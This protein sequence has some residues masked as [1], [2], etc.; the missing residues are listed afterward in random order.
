MRKLAVV[1]TWGLQILMGVMFVALGTGKFND[2]G[3][4]RSFARWGYPEGF[5]FVI[6]V[7][8][9][10]GGLALLVP[11]FVPY[12]AALLM[13]VMLGAVLTHAV[14]GETNR[15]MV[16]LVYTALVGLVGWLR[17]DR[18]PVRRARRRGLDAP[19]VQAG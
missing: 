15:L 2:P 7:A 17:R 5:H 6:G 11:R 10:L 4:A 19:T 16:P 12:G 18:W 9:A 8:E 13:A 14:H 3:W 1:L